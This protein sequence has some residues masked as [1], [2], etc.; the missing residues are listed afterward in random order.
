VKPEALNALQTEIHAWHLRNYPTDTVHQA[1]LGMGEEI[2]E[3]D[4]ADVKQHGGIRGTWDEW[5]AEKKKEAGDVLIGLLNFCGFVNVDI[6]EAL[7]RIGPV[8][9]DD[10]KA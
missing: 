7:N 10:L 6:N 9:V 3:L 8:T 4:R 2:G 5:Q 1:I